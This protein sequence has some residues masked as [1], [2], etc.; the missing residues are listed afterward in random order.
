MADPPV[1]VAST[2]TTDEHELRA[3]TLEDRELS[4]DLEL[5]PADGGRQAHLT[6]LACSILQIP[7]WGRSKTSR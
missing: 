3:S 7:V 6:L 2:P 1:E 4:T 5:P